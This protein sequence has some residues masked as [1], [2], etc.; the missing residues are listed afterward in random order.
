MV[1]IIGSQNSSNS[2]RL[3][4]IALNNNIPAYLIDSPQEIN[5]NWLNN[6]KTIGITAGASAPEYIIQETIDY[7]C[8]LSSQVNI[9]E[10]DTITENT[11]FPIPKINI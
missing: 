2:Q 3:K 9:R 6:I 10:L 4:E 5:I 7:L 11:K 8:N 1:V